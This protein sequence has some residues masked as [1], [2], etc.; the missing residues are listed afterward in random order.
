VSTTPATT[1]SRQQCQATRKDGRPCTAFAVRQG[2]C[3]GHL[4]SAIEARRKG[5]RQRARIARLHSLVPTRLL[6]VYDA[7][8][9]AL[10]EVHGG[11]IDPR[12][13]TAMASLA[14]AM[15]RVLTAGELEERVRR[16]ES[17]PSGGGPIK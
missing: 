16:L 11:K 1:S 2:R 14:G 12:I 7:L 6:T 15:V 8:D 13:A 9:D 10:K 5:G 4:P 17:R 3:V